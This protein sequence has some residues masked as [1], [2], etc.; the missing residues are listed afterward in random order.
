MATCPRGN[1]PEYI[2]HTI[3]DAQRE[4][5]HWFSNG[6]SAQG[7]L[8]QRLRIALSNINQGGDGSNGL[9]VDCI[10]ETCPYIVNFTPLRR[11]F[12]V[13]WYFE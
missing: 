1:R 2:K 13:K 12:S 6:H 8:V 3:Q 9:T 7:G 5:E 4:G 11:M 10:S